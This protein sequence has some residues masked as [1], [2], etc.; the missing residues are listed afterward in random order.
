MMYR[1][2]LLM[3]MLLTCS[4][5][6]AQ[7]ATTPSV[8]TSP[9]YARGTTG[10]GP[11]QLFRALRS[12]SMPSRIPLDPDFQGSFNAAPDDSTRVASL[13][14]NA[15]PAV[16][17]EATPDAEPTPAQL[18]QDI[19]RDARRLQAGVRA[20]VA[21]DPELLLIGVQAQLGLTSNVFFRPSV[22]FGWGEVTSMFGFNGEFMVFRGPRRRIAGHPTSVG[23]WESTCCTRTL[24]GITAADELTSGISTVI[25]RSTFS[26]EFV[27][28]TVCL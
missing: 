26:A 19:Q 1:V 14:F 22:D 21:M 9:A 10:A 2:T 28:A 3:T 12:A 11:S 13:L 24:C 15:K 25:L 23:A 17:M 4:I 20:G 7:N 27:T 16:A 6:R 18:D 8:S 5:A